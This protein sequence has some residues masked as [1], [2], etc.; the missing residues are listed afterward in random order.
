MR[1]DPESWLFVD[2]TPEEAAQIEEVA[3]AISM[4]TRAVHPEQEPLWQ[5]WAEVYP[6]PMGQLLLVFA[7]VFPLRCFASVVHYRA[8]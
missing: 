6:V 1:V 7:T 2:L 4:G 8:H 5:M 3:M